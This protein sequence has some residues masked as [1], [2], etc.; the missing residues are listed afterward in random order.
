MCYQQMLVL[1]VWETGDVALI[2]STLP[3]L[4][5]LGKKKFGLFCWIYLLFAMQ[6]CAVV[7]TVLLFPF[8]V[9]RTN[10]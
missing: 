7:A 2:F 10:S 4:S 5:R 8:T 6:F 1:L 3:D 9:L